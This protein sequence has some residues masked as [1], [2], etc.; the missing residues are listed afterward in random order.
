[1]TNSQSLNSRDAKLNQN[2]IRREK[3]VAMAI[4]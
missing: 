1:M 2:S 4:L 3:S